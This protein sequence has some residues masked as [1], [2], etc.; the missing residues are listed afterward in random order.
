MAVLRQRSIAV[1]LALV[2]AGSVLSVVL[3]LTRPE[4]AGV[5]V[6]PSATGAT[7]PG[8]RPADLVGPG[9]DALAAA[10]DAVP[11][12]FSYDHRD[13]AGSLASATDQM[14]RSYAAVFRRTFDARVRPFAKRRAAVAEGLVRGAGVVRTDGDDAAVCLLYVDQLLVEA[15]GRRKAAPPEVLA[16]SRIRVELV[17][18][19]GV[20]RINGLRSV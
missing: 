3:A 15:R 9:G 17:L 12:T 16:R 5:G 1:L 19:D 6:P 18:R 20:W 13:L 7:A 2:L 11:A 8:F 4:A 10:V 14:T